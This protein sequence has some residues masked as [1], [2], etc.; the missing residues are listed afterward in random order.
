MRPLT[1][2][3]NIMHFARSVMVC[4]THDYC[5]TQYDELNH[6]QLLQHVLPEIYVNLL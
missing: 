2:I 3:V 5:C 4:L 1:K 6:H